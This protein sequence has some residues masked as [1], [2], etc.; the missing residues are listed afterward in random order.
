MRARQSKGGIV[1]KNEVKSW[2]EGCGGSE[3]QGVCA[4]DLHAFKVWYEEVWVKC[5]TSEFWIFDK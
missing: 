4:S 1:S 5:Q 3:C 2:I